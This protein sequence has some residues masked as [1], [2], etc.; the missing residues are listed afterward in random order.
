MSFNEFNPNC[1]DLLRH[2]T[3]LDDRFDTHYDTGE[4]KLF[5]TFIK[6]LTEMPAKDLNKNEILKIR[7][8]LTKFENIID[9]ALP[10]SINQTQNNQ[11][12]TAEKTSHYT[13]KRGPFFKDA[14]DLL[15]CLSSKIQKALKSQDF[16][17]A[18]SI[19]LTMPRDQNRLQCWK[20]AYTELAR[21]ASPN[22][23]ELF[24]LT[25]V[26]EA[27]DMPG[28]FLAIES[29][30]AISSLQTRRE[31]YTQ[32]CSQAKNVLSK[33]ELEDF[34]V[35]CVD[36]LL[37]ENNTDFINIADQII[38]QPNLSSDQVPLV[39]IMKNLPENKRKGLFERST[40]MDLE[41]NS[42]V[43]FTNRRAV[44]QAAIRCE[45]FESALSIIALPASKAGRRELL[46]LAS[47]E[48]KT[49]FPLNKQKDFL[50]VCVDKALDAKDCSIATEAAEVFEP[51]IDIPNDPFVGL[52]NIILSL[53]KDKQK[54]RFK[55]S[56]LM[57][58][59]QSKFISA[60][61]LAERVSDPI[62]KEHVLS[63]IVDKALLKE[64]FFA[65]FA[66]AEKISDK[67]LRLTLFA[68]VAKQAL[69]KNALFL[70]IRAA[71]QILAEVKKNDLGPLGASSITKKWI[72]EADKLL[73][74]I[75]TKALNEKQESKGIAFH[76]VSNMSTLE[77]KEIFF[78]PIAQQAL[79]NENFFIATEAAKSIPIQEERD[80]FLSLIAQQALEKKLFHAA[81]CAAGEMS[82]TSTRLLTSPSDY[83]TDSE[84]DST[85]PSSPVIQNTLRPK[86]YPSP[87]VIRDSNSNSPFTDIDSKMSYS[88]S[89][90]TNEKF[91]SRKDLLLKIIEES[92]ASNDSSAAT[93]AKKKLEG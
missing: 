9:S 56:I 12:T 15:S 57:A 40:I 39:N 17:T 29:I 86:T 5:H 18:V 54:D 20:N 78:N 30:K 59:S 55:S 1:T 79:E 65:A 2:A 37:K 47:L 92:L 64:D 41:S 35:V 7:S 89:S 90:V 28:F 19:L 70:S 91:L 52:Y 6:T 26:N 45:D 80:A 87:V 31:S 42:T 85:A 69:D 14:K 84:Q 76:A 10:K 8:I 32:I 49:Q 88:P 25:C 72:D 58:L 4:G 51:N 60:I 75:T 73:L 23:K 74:L 81:A 11:K 63:I 67:K 83:I 68:N 43:F 46:E 27:S 48:L 61:R 22:D 34:L 62:K 13:Q 21:T 66:G 33:E 3:L 50:N 16:K 36:E 44:L 77:R 24:L 82:V 71:R 53:S 93:Y 38:L